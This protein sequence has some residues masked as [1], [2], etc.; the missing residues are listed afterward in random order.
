MG[1]ILTEVKDEL[2]AERVKSDEGDVLAVGLFL[3]PV[4]DF[5]ELQLK[6]PE[7]SIFI[8]YLEKGTLSTDQK[9]R[10]RLEHDAQNFFMK[11]GKL[12][13]RQ[14]WTGRRQN[15]QEAMIQLVVPLSERK[16][17]LHAFQK[18][19]HSGFDKCYQAVTRV[20]FWYQL[21]KNLKTFIRT[22]P[23][24]QT[25]KSYQKYKVFLKPLGIRPGFGHTLHLD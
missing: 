2:M 8:E 1:E 13:H 6:C 21:Y 23:D 16:D 22:C 25:S 9:W 3:E 17:V 19:S 5:G 10:R 7:V 4:T 18:L 15:F 20:Y 12:W 24:C 11:E 14:E